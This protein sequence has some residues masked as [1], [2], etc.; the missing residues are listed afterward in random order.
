VLYYKGGIVGET[1]HT[2]TDSC[3]CPFAAL[4]LMEQKE[5]AAEAQK[6]CFDFYLHK[7]LSLRGSLVGPRFL[8]CRFQQF[9]V[10]S[11]RGRK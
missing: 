9:P 2:Q 8:H 3:R 11:S 1:F 6:A 10:V 4:E 5:L 7:M